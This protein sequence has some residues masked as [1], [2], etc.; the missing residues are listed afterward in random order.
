ME[1]KLGQQ[2]R[3]GSPWPFTT[4]T[5]RLGSLSFAPKNVSRPFTASS[6]RS[7]RPQSSHSTPQDPEP[8]TIPNGALARR[9]FPSAG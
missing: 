5:E 3:A 9:T 2:L 7:S 1:Q 6:F 4:V 8:S